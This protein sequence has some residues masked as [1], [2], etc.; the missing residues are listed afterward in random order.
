MF[1]ATLRKRVFLENIKCV[2]GFARE[3]YSKS[4]QLLTLLFSSEIKVFEALKIVT[5][6]RY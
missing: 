3:C 4:S 6:V 1:C 2:Y 5:Y